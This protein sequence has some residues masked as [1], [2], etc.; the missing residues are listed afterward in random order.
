M[1]NWGSFG[2]FEH[3]N[4]Y[5]PS[6]KFDST[7]LQ[8]LVQ[9]S[10]FFYSCYVSEISAANKANVCTFAVLG[11]Q[12]VP[13]PV[14]TSKEKTLLSLFNLTIVLETQNVVKS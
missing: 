12:Q 4:D 8:R 11:P 6:L 13:Q 10:N 9:T 14:S 3:L 7:T 5:C 1:T 2:L